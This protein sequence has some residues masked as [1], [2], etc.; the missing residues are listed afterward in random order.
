[1][2]IIICTLD[3]EVMGYVY[4]KYINTYIRNMMVWLCEIKWWNDK[5]KSFMQWFAKIINLKVMDYYS[6]NF[7]AKIEQWK[8][9]ISKH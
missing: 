6:N 8:L 7:Y 5:F 4:M 1:M 2:F 3:E 9:F